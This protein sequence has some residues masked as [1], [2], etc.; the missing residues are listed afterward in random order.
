ML[1]FSN[2]L[3]QNKTLVYF[4]HEENLMGLAAVG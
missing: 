1:T 2:I 4:K 3:K